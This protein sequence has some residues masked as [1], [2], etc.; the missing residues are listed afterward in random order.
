MIE[1]IFL[2]NLFLKNLFKYHNLLIYLIVKVI[3]YRYQISIY[4]YI[5]NVLFK[6]MVKTYFSILLKY[7]KYLNYLFISE[8]WI[9]HIILKFFTYYSF[10]YYFL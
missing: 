10:T 2:Y 8:P 7:V 1:K 3:K 5:F 4:I 6:V 9:L